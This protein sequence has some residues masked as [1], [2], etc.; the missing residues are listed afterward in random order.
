[1][2][3]MSIKWLGRASRSFIMGIRLWPPLRILA[4][5]PCCC[6]NAMASGTFL[7]RRYSKAGGI[8]FHLFQHRSIN[9]DEGLKRYS[10]EGHSYIISPAS[11]GNTRVGR[12]L[13][14]LIIDDHDS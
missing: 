12:A 2:R 10:P 13:L 6:S 14:I 9:S 8:M 3:L 5:S 1:M 4:S 7:G 11:E